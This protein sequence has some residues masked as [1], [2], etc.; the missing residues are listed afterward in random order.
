MCPPAGSSQLQSLELNL[1]PDAESSFCFDPIA[2]LL[3]SA[4]R[5]AEERLGADQSVG[6]WLPWF[7]FRHQSTGST[8]SR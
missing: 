8:F 2:D 4:C 1:A 6:F 5:C 3:A 7:A